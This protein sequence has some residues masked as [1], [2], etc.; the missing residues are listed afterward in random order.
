V[1][2]QSLP[3]QREADE[4]VKLRLA[5]GEGVHSAGSGDP[6]GGAGLVAPREEIDQLTDVDVN[7]VVVRPTAQG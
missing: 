1:E 2:A 6:L 4:V 7:E 5:L 3:P